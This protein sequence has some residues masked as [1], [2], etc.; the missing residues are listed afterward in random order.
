MLAWGKS[1][2]RKLSQ[3]YWNY[4]LKKLY[5]HQL[6]LLTL[7]VCTGWLIRFWTQVEGDELHS[8]YMHIRLNSFNDCVEKCHN[9][10]VLLYRKIFLFWAKRDI[11]R[12]LPENGHISL[13]AVHVINQEGPWRHG[14]QLRVGAPCYR[15]LKNW[16]AGFQ[17]ETQPLES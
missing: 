14:C 12:N 1:N 9:L 10:V 13:H 16:A 4:R 8:C 2:M 17:L 6:K 5:N 3:L 7:S 11:V 15:R